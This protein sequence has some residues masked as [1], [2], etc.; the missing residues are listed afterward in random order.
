M[1]IAKAIV[2]RSS[3]PS[4]SKI[5]ITKNSPL[6]WKFAKTNAGGEHLSDYITGS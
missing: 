2:S 3:F 1:K 4:R 6:P 5:W